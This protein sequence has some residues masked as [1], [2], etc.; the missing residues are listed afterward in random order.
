[1][2]IFTHATWWKNLC[3]G[4]LV[5]RASGAGRYRAGRAGGRGPAGHRCPAGRT[6]AKVPGDAGFYQVTFDRQGIPRTEEVEKAVQTV[7]MG[8]C[9]A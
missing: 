8:L 4:A 1:V 3:G 9:T 7:V 2:Y 6:P 5:T